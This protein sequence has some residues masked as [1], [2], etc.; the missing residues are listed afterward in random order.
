MDGSEQHGAEGLGFK[1]VKLVQ[2]DRGGVEDGALV[3]LD[4]PALHLHAVGDHLRAS[5]LQLRRRRALPRR[6]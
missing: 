4:G 1:V 3:G 5:R 2:L 6:R